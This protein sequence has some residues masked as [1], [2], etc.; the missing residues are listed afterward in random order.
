VVLSDSLLERAKA[1]GVETETIT[2]SD[3]TKI[4]YVPPKQV[5]FRMDLAGKVEKRS[6]IGF[7]PDQTDVV[8]PLRA[9]FKLYDKN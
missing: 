4:E 3:G 2:E 7:G 8:H 5:E 6:I 9:C 1:L